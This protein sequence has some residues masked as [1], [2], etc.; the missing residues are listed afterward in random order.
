MTHFLKASLLLVVIA[1]AAS[2]KKPVGFEYRGINKVNLE[3]V[4]MDRSTV[5]LDMVYYNPNNFGVNLKHVECDVFVDTSFI[6]KYLLDT[7]MHID[8]QAEFTIPT[9]MEVDMRNLLKGGIFA[10]LGQ[11]VQITVKG[12]TRVGK[13]GIFIN[14]PF[15]F[16]GKYDI[17]LFR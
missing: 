1:A 6:G 11:K 10:L 17:P 16:T 12:R 14:V 7:V 15:D 5:L 9:R 13:G 8:R 4:S 3:N 2:C